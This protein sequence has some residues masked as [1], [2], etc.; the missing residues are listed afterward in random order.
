MLWIGIVI[1]I[2]LGWAIFMGIVV[3]CGAASEG[4]N[5]SKKV[6]YE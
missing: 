3:L 4:D 5:R 1:G 2:F 6:T